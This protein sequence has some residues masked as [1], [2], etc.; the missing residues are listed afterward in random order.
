M[1][2]K[3]LCYEGVRSSIILLHENSYLNSFF[4]IRPFFM[5]SD[6]LQTLR[7]FTEEIHWVTMMGQ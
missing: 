1:A 4:H 3:G 6:I 5:A 7:Y 2:D